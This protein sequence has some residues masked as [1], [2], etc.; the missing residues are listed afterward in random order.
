MAI[1]SDKSD[2]WQTLNILVCSSLTKQIYKVLA[3]C[4][5]K[6]LVDL[7]EKIIAPSTQMSIA[8]GMLFQ[9]WHLHAHL[10]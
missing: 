2:R 4:V 3:S 1:R 5:P 6:G 8:C 7:H 9:F 10:C